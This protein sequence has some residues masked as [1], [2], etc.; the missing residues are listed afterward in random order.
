ML[1]IGPC[2]SAVAVIL[3]VLSNGAAAQIENVQ[4]SPDVTL[5]LGGALIADEGVA[6]DDL[7]GNVV[8]VAI[9]AIPANADLSV[10]HMLDNGNSLLALDVTVELPGGLIAQPRDVVQ[11][12]GGVYSIVF[13]GSAQGIPA[14]VRLDALGAD[15]DGNLLMSFD[16]TVALSGITADDED[17][18][19][20]DGTDFSLFFDGSAAGIPA[21]PDLDAL[22]FVPETGRL[23]L[24]FDTGGMVGG[25]VFSDEDLLEHDIVGGG[26]SLAYDGSAEHGDWVAGDLDAAFVAFL[27]GFIFKDGF[28]DL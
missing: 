11:Y 9:G 19:E 17:I 15:A 7:S 18:V 24:S 22:H 1:R 8:P 6:A 25:T 23:F 16:T 10:Y 27:V 13:D 21:G 28:E 2:R 3:I 14:G 4:L 26:W 20:F 12:S 5:T